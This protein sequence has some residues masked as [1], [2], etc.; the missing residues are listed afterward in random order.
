MAN[1]LGNWNPVMY[2]QEALIWLHGNLGMA[3]RVH[4]GFDAER[5]TFNKGDTINIKRPALFTAQAA[6][7]SMQDLTTENVSIVVD[8]HFEVRYPLSDKELAYTGAQI[9]A[10]HVGPAANAL[11]EH[12]DQAL[13]SLYKKVPWYV[14]AAGSTPVLDDINAI[15]ALMA[16]NKVPENDPSKLHLMIGSTER[17]HLIGL[18]ALG[19]HS[20]GGQAGVLTRQ[21][22]K[23][24]QISGYTPFMNQNRPTHT[25]TAMNTA[26][27]AVQGA[28]AVGATSIILDAGTLTGSMAIGDSFVIAGNTQRYAVTAAATAASNAITL[29]FE[30]PLVAAA[31]DNAVA[32][33]H[34]AATKNKVSMAFHR[35][36]FALAFAR[37]PDYGEFG[38]NLGAAVSSVQDPV[39]GIAVRAKIYGDHANSRV[40][41]CFDALYGVKLLNNKLACRFHNS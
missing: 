15:Q 14:D 37:L 7:G 28:T 38:S 10:D 5:R 1:T 11:G 21:T 22:G 39:S 2:A 41:V 31:A 29:T 36:S 34:Q 32:T 4:M 3:S 35:D 24:D 16:E 17:R 30:P 13:A 23:L 40:G 27:C 20:G 12:I 6:P 18:T 9:I 8:Q 19:Q 26:T 25:T 33:T